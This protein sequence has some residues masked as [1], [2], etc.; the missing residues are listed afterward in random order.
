MPSVLTAKM[1]PGLS[2]STPDQSNDWPLPARVVLG[3]TGVA[4]VLVTISV[5]SQIYLLQA[6]EH[7]PLSRV[8]RRFSLDAELS[9]PAWYATVLLLVCGGMLAVIARHVRQRG[10]RFGF[11]WMLLSLIFV[12]LS[13]DEA[14]AFHEIAMDR[15]ESLDTGGIFY[16]L[17]VW[18][19]LPIVVLVGLFYLPLVLSLP[20]RIAV[21]FTIAGLVFLGGALGAE[22]VSGWII[23]HYGIDKMVYIL[24]TTIEECMEY[25]GVILFLYALMRYRSVLTDA[26]PVPAD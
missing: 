3:L 4:A 13:I 19:A 10:G 18:A 7:A 14:C 1:S 5:T 16:F 2:V 22:A 23:D 11:R 21:M 12:G 17:W 25:A 6:G 15:F 20:R 9:V 24:T 8:L 26:A